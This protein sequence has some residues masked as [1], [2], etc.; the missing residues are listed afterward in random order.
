MPPVAPICRAASFMQFWTDGR[1]ALGRP[2]R[3]ALSVAGPVE[4]GGGVV[5][6]RDTLFPRIRTRLVKSLGGYGALAEWAEA[7]DMRVGAPGL[8]TMAGPLGAI[9]VGLGA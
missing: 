3:L 8:G 1:A 2:L 7:I 9:A 6:A 5:S 4:A